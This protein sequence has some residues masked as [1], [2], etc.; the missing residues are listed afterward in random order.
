M[1]E[2]LAASVK[3]SEEQVSKSNA[4]SAS[5]SLKTED[6]WIAIRAAEL[7]RAYVEFARES[8]RLA[9]LARRQK[10]VPIP[11]EGFNQLL[12]EKM[13]D[14]E[15]LF[16]LYIRRKEELLACLQTTAR[17]NE[18]TEQRKVRPGRRSAGQ[19]A[20]NGETERAA[21]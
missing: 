1:G 21:S 9:R 7:E 14:V 4:G 5:P 16:L 18:F 11:S 10:K 3:A 15:R 12:T 8:G 2:A 6:R 19:G 13:E 20:R 17:R